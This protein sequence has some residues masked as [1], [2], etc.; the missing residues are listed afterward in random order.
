M[1]S[2]AVCASATTWSTVWIG[3]F[4]IP[5]ASSRAAHTA[6][7]S[8]ANRSERI[9]ISAGAVDDPVAV[10]AEARILGEARPADRAAQTAEQIVVAGGD[11]DVPVG[12]GEGLIRDDRFDTGAVPLRDLA[13][14]EVGRDRQRHPGERRLVERSVD[15][16][17]APGAPTFLQRGEDADHRPHRRRHVDDR[18]GD[19]NRRSSVLAQQAH[20]PAIGLHHR[21]VARPVA[22]RPGRAEGSDIAIDEARLLGGQRGGGEAIPVERAVFEVVDQR[23]RRARGSARAAFRPEPDRRGRS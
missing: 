21:I 11:H 9:G 8:V 5:A 10:G 7:G 15:D 13:I 3:P 22:Q 12:G 2:A 4:G 20:Q 18:D 6:I 23:R 17:A 14:G 16:P 1:P 19:P